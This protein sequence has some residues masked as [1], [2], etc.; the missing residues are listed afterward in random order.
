MNEISKCI[1]EL[2]RTSSATF[3][4]RFKDLL[5]THLKKEKGSSQVC[6]Y[7]IIISN[8]QIIIRQ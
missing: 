1:F 6:D 4:F 5:F 8:E 2:E 3:I 7:D